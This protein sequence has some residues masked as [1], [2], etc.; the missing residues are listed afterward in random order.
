MF[1]DLSVGSMLQ[2]NSLSNWDNPLIKTNILLAGA[3]IVFLASILY[4]ANSVPNS[5]R[6]LLKNSNYRANYGT[7]Y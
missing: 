6:I 3:N 2:L 5:N 1:L 4:L 7:L